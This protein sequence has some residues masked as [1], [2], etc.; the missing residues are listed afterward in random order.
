MNI[1]GVFF[2]YNEYSGSYDF[3]FFSSSKLPIMIPAVM[4]TVC[5]NL[6]TDHER[7]TPKNKRKSPKVYGCLMYE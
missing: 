1:S 4:K 5:N 3:N 7:L 6:P 2:M